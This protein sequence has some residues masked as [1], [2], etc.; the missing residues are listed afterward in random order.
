MKRP[1]SVTA[2]LLMSASFALYV[3]TLAP[4][5]L[6]GDPAEFQTIAY[7]LGIGH[8]T[9]YPVY[10]LL[11]KLFT[12]LPVREVA[13]RVNLFS[14]FCA[15]LT[16]ATVYLIIRK[17]GGKVVPALYGSLA[18]A[19]APVF[20]K[21]A[22]MAE[23][24]TPSTA[25]LAFI[26]LA[27][28]QWKETNNPRW[29]WAAGISGGLSLGIHTTIALAAPAILIHL[30]ISPPL[31]GE[32][33]EMRVKP[34]LAG[35]TIGALI[36]LASFLLLDR[37]NSPAGY[38]NTVV[39][40]SLSTW[41]MTLA[42]FDSPF[43]RLAFLYIPPQFKGEFF[44][45][46]FH[47]SISRIQA[48][49]K[50]ASWSLWLALPGF[51]SLFIPRRTHPSR[52]HEAVLLMLACSA[53]L[54]FAATYHVDDYY[55]YFI[56]AM[57]ILVIFIGLGVNAIVESAASVPG[58]PKPI[59]GALGIA[60]LVLGF[61]PSIAGAASHW[62]ERMPPGLED[63]EKLFYEYPDARR[64]EME[65]IVNSLEDHAIVF[66][67][68]DQAYGFYYVAHVQQGRR[69]ISF[70]ETHPQEG[71]P[72]LA[73]SASAYIEANIDVRPIYFSERPS[74]P[75][76]EFKVTRTGLGLFRIARK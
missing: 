20:W 9:G 75:G 52:W 46:P 13:Y 65:K 15:A 55:V 37:L 16:V 1:D 31:M 4:S 24:Y 36:F 63:W 44:N 25:C 68:W 61:Y 29:L 35:A 27:V 26:L 28:L 73:E 3:R 10:I 42:D 23:I 38:Y 19:F 57:V 58:L 51:I 53:Y 48:F 18:L 74:Q 49:A 22:S 12:L 14:A 69:G 21:Q 45:V 54:V 64:F 56:P 47:E 67:D 43:E 7:T 11:A 30:F 17:L 39:Y 5:L 60:I 33:P 66:T 40:P 62:S 50:E 70:H 72:Q 2:F 59:Q 8:P 71:V 76:S 41:D 34:A 6:Y 32:R